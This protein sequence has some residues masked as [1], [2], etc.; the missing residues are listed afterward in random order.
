MTVTHRNE[1][2][3]P[4]VAIC[5]RPNVGK[6]TLFNRIIGKQ[7]AIVHDEEG[8]TRDR[9][10]GTASWF[11]RR[12]RVVDTGGI[13]E[14][15]VDEIS[16]KMQEQ[17]MA[18]LREA[19]VILFVVDGR[20]DITRT[21][22]VVAESL[23]RLG[24]PV[25]VVANKLDNAAQESLCV[26]FYALGLGTPIP[27][28]AG[29]NRGVEELV[30]AAIALLDGTDA[31]A[32]DTA[33]ETDA[34]PDERSG[35]PP[36]PAGEPAEKDTVIRVAIV[37]RPNAGKSSFINALLNEDRVIVSTV[38]GTTRD[39]IDVE[40]TWQGR[41]YVLADTAGLRRKAGIRKE[42]EKF[43]VARTL[44]AVRQ[45]DVCV[46]MVDAVEGLADQDKR[47]IGYAMEQGTGIVLAWTKWDLVEDK[48]RRFRQLADM[49]DRE[50]PQIRFVPRVTM[51]NV[52]KQ[53]VFAVLEHV[54][55][56][57]DGCRKR[58]ATAELNRLIEAIKA[59]HNPPSQKGK[60]AKILYATQAGVKPT[61][62]VLFVNQKRL[63][64]FSYLRYIENALREAYGF[65]GVPIRIELREEAR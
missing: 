27:V 23:R 8:I 54:N 50:M 53:R 28:S 42:V 37:G 55:R 36:V 9:F 47:I 25:L 26:E 60:H 49:I 22:Q 48:D 62:F 18:A 14:S 39:A 29:H 5:G 33:G 21:D 38:P 63:F 32:S 44:R 10:Y 16:R 3:L 13:M 51:S 57:A 56:V 31:V 20:T 61:V 45:A 1:N 17:V 15:P 65:E 30:R 46:V 34:P 64:H 43:S 7:R 35:E 12:F 4:L 19:E 24:K 40:F 11:G 58:I 52:T 6:S 41:H 2:R 59:R